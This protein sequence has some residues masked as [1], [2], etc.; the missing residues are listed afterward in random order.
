MG[1]GDGVLNDR[2]LSTFTQI[3]NEIKKIKLLINNKILNPQNKQVSTVME[4]I[5]SIVFY[6]NN[7]LTLNINRR[8]MKNQDE[9]VRF[10]IVSTYK[11]RR[12][13]DVIFSK[14]F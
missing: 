5:C 4:N 14:L 11:V 8:L 13:K 1:T 12:V 2:E 10:Y 7:S 9:E 6:I 3:Q